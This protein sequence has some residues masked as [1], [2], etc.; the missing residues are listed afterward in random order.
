V[1]AARISQIE[2]LLPADAGKLGK[3]PAHAFARRA[4]HPDPLLWITEDGRLVEHSG[5]SSGTQTGTKVDAGHGFGDDL[6]EAEDQFARA[7]GP[8]VPVL[9]ERREH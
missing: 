4:I 3:S 8:E 9:V 1:P 7:E 5:V 6:P 2:L